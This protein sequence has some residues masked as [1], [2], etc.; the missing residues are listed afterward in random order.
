VLVCAS[1]GAPGT[2][3]AKHVFTSADGGVIWQNAVAAPAL[4][5]AISL[6]ATSAGTKV[7]ATGQGIDVQPAGS[8]AWQPATLDGP[9]P[10]GGFGYVGMTTDSQGVA[11][12]ADPAI[13]TVWFQLRRREDLDAV[14]GRLD[15]SSPWSRTNIG[16]DQVK[17]PQLMT[18]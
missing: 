6:A 15:R 5:L 7:L 9:A 3:Q 18:T 8:A 12:P 1:S 17:R 16:L 2:Q 14:P 13:G 4:G 10:A 11:L